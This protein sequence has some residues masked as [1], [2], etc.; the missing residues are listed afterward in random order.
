MLDGPVIHIMS[1]P[2]VVRQHPYLSRRPII[3]DN[4]T[5]LLPPVQIAHLVD[6]WNRVMNLV[7]QTTMATFLTNTPQWND[8]SDKSNKD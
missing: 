7:D 2:V 8:T 6:K 3:Y 4:Q 1:F 5:R